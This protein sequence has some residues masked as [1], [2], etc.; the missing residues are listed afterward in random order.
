MQNEIHR[1]FSEFNRV[2]RILANI[3]IAAVV[4]LHLRPVE[5]D[6]KLV[7]SMQ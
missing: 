3:F 4:L 2:N 5:Q 1:R 7:I 6:S